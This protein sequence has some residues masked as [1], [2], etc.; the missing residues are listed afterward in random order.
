MRAFTQTHTN[1]TQHA[2]NITHQTTPTPHTH[3]HTQQLTH[4]Q[5]ETGRVPQVPIELESGARLVRLRQ[6]GAGADGGAAQ[7][8]RV[9]A[10]RIRAHGHYGPVV[11]ALHGVRTTHNSTHTHHCYTSNSYTRSFPFA[12][13]TLCLH[14]HNAALTTS[15]YEHQPGVDAGALT[16]S[17][18]RQ[19]F[20][21]IFKPEH[22]LFERSELGLHYLPVR[23]QPCNCVCVFV[24]NVFVWALYRTDFISGR[25]VRHR[26]V[27]VCMYVC[28]LAN[29]ISHFEGFEPR[30]GA[31][32]A[33]R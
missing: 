32:G 27:S 26:V 10:V 31:D 9:G 29:F 22:R 16:T 23:Y 25:L 8:R 6:G 21:E 18:Y 11:S 5:Q 19:F 20:E 3:T 2:T 12:R 28:V 17:M 33:S 7:R 1:H 14:L 4:T 15:R 13:T 24:T 30:Q